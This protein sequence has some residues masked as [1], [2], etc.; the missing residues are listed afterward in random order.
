VDEKTWEFKLRPGVKFTNGTPFTAKDVVYTLCRIPTVE[1]S[2]SPFTVY[3]RGFEAIE[4]P[5]PQTVIFKT[6]APTPLLPNNLST[7]GILSAD[8]YGG[9]NVKWA[10]GGCQDM[11]TPPKSAEFNEP[12]QGGR[13]RPLQARQLHPGHPRDPGAQRRLLGRQAPL[14]EGD[15]AS[16]HQRGP[17]RGGAARRRRGR[18]REPADPGLRQDQGRRLPGRPGISNRIIYLHMDQHND[19]AWKTPA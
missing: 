3:T 19:P 17:A 7:L 18:D 4:T 13:H 14:A 8:A 15:L 12:W 16:G 10:A 2:P 5:D 6:A 1:N 11:G 9:G